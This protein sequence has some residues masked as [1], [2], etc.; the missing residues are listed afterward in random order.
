MIYKES[1]TLP[2]SKTQIIEKMIQLSISRTTLK[3]LGKKYTEI[4][5][6]EHLLYL[7]G[8]LAWEALQRDSMELLIRH[9]RNTR[10]GLVLFHLRKVGSI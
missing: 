8:K 7:V 10:F 2:A 1:K 6:L 3:T 9:V 4:E 5:D